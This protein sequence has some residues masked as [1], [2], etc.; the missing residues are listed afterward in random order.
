M[1]DD[2]FDV[3]Y[4]Y[5][6]LNQFGLAVRYPS[7]ADQSGSNGFETDNGPND[8]DVAPYTTGVFSNYTIIGPKLTSAQSIN[9]NFQHVM[10]MR[11][12]TAVTIDN[13]VFA[14]FPRGLRMN[15]PSVL[16]NYQNNTGALFNNIMLA[17][18][19]TFTAGSG[20][21]AN[22]VKTYWEANNEVST[23]ADYATVIAGWGLNPNIFFGN[24]VS[25]AYSPSPTFTVTSGALLTGANFTN[26]KVNSSFFTQVSYRGAFGAT[27]WTAGWAEFNPINKAY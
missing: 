5:S 21:N 22:D 8:N 11:R 16:S 7:Y 18:A 19:Q 26:S 6:G 23:S 25:T 27:N 14:G 9:A 1:W 3:D 2:D 12:R 13:S 24:N 15:Q 10:D 4:G 17:D 20:M